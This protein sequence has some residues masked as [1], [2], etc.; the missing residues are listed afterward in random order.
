MINDRVNGERAALAR[1]QAHEIKIVKSRGPTV[2]PAPIRPAA[3]RWLDTDAPLHRFF[4]RPP[5]LRPN[6]AA[7]DR[8]AQ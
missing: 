8:N 2:A 5:G 3:N 4:S 6:I 7:A 1:R